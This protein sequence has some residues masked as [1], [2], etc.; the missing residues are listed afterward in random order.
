M[1]CRACQNPTRLVY[2][3]GYCYLAGMYAATIDE[4]LQAERYPMELHTCDTCGVLQIH[5]LPKIEKV[6]NDEYKYR[7][8]NVP[9]LVEH[10]EEFAL[11]IQ[12][13]LKKGARILEFGSNDGTFLE[14]LIG[15]GFDAI[16]MDASRNIVELAN[17]LGRPTD[18]GFFGANSNKYSNESFDAITCSNV[19]AHAPNIKALTEE[20]WRLLKDDGYFLI[21]VHDASKL[22]HGHFDAIYH[23]HSVYYCPDSISFHLISNGFEVAMLSRTEMHGGGLRVVA[24]KTGKQTDAEMDVV[25]IVERQLTEAKSIPLTIRNIRQKLFD[26][27]AGKKFDLYGIAGKTQMFVHHAK[28][29]NLIHRAFDDS[30]LRSGKYIVGTKTKIEE[31]NP[32]SKLGE[33]A[34]IGAWNYADHIS[35]RIKKHYRK[36]ITLLPEYKEW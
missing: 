29:H 24:R 26:V 16:G 21:E 11:E 17:R 18:L 5:S 8:G 12:D 27:T 35:S 20:A 10:F 3:F 9:G 22:F 23:E 34:V 1:A 4:A 32:N 19:Y 30:E 28:I 36:V 31:F 25:S 6:F 33:V 13:I 14:K 7:T 2:D 15:L